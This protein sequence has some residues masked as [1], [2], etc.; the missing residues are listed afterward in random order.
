MAQNADFV[1][2]SLPRSSR[3][4]NTLISAATVMAHNEGFI[5]YHV[6]APNYA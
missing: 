5:V 4:H 1:V 2:H 6:H 3:K